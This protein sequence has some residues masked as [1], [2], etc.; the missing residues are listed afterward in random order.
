MYAAVRLAVQYEVR[1]LDRSTNNLGVNP[2]LKRIDMEK[3]DQYLPL[4]LGQKFRFKI[5]GAEKWT[6]LSN[7]GM[8]AMDL[9]KITMNT[10]TF[11]V[12]FLLRPLSSMRE[13]EMKELYTFVF[14]KRTFTGDNI[15]HR[16]KGTKDERWVL[17]SGLE[18]LFIYKD[19]DVGADIDLHH[20]RVN[21][22]EVVKWQLSKGFDIFGLKE[23]G[24]CIYENELNPE[25][26]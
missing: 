20:F 23:K 4:Y 16:D 15:T 8:T 10:D 21:H 24:L 19:G 2:P 22:P 25:G 5:N 14:R 12:Q 17:W 9:H 26:H 1:V 6:S 11:E 3:I 7:S 13:E 18:R